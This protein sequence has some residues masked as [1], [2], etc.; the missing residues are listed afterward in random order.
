MELP[1][2]RYQALHTRINEANKAIT[3]LTS[4]TLLP[5]A[6]GHRAGMVF[7]LR[8]LL[9]ANVRKRPVF[10]DGKIGGFEATDTDHE[11]HYDFVP[12]GLT[13]RVRQRCGVDTVLSLLLATACSHP[14]TTGAPQGAVQAPQGGSTA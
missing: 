3:N 14:L 1:T 2:D 11:R 13:K 10:F 12:W 9:D 7:T 8:E 4:Q 6:Q 5:L